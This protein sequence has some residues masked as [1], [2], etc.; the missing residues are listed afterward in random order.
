LVP[1]D[2]QVD[3]WGGD[4]RF[5]AVGPLAASAYYWWVV[6]AIDMA[7]VWSGGRR[8]LEVSKVVGGK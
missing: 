3:V 1:L 7:C 8:G 4:C 6:D 2:S 5:P